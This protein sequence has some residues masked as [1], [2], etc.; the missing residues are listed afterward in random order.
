MGKRFSDLEDV[1]RTL[2][3]INFNWDSLPANNKYRK[4]REWVEDPE[5][6]TRDE[7]RVPDTG[8]RIAIGLQAFGFP[9]DD[10][11]KVRVKISGQVNTNIAALGGGTLYNHAATLDDTYVRR[12]GFI[13][14]K[15]I[16]AG[17]VG[18]PGANVAGSAPLAGGNPVSS[19]TG[20]KYKVSTKGSSTV[21]F[22]GTTATETEFDI[23]NEII[24]DRDTEFVVT[25]T[26]ERLKRT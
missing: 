16:L 5:K 22:G 10:T 12:V 15:A 18:T 19:I 20:K 3:A 1:Y 13:P 14:A 11:G 26:P 17:R 8:R 2:S 25:F 21:P 7:A 6:R 23:Q 9:L 24:N 4:Y